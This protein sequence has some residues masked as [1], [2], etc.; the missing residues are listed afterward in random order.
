MR[1]RARR[2]RTRLLVAMMAIS[3]GVLVLAA[4]GAAGLARET[5]ADDALDDLKR[6]APTIARQLKTL[7]REAARLREGGLTG[8]RFCVVIAGLLRATGGSVVT[9]DANGVAS[10][11]FGGVLPCASSGAELVELP[12]NLTIADLDTDALLAG[13]LQSGVKDDTAFVAQPIAGVGN[14]IAVVVLTQAVE[15]RPLGQAGPYLFFT[16]LF[17]LILAAIVSAFLARRLTRPLGAMESTAGRIAAGDLSAR[18]GAASMPY[19]ELGSLAHSIDTM[20]DELETSRGHERAFLL[21]I[22]HDLRTPLTSIKGYAEGMADGVIESAP[23]RAR[24][25]AVI[26]A[27][28]RRLERLVADLLDL[29]R[30]DTHEFS[31]TRV[32]VDARATVTATVQGFAPALGELGVQLSVSSGA[33]INMNTDPERLA[34]IV[35]NL[36]ENAL[37]YAATS[38]LVDVSEHDGTVELRVDDDGPGIP[39]TERGRVFDRLYTV[40][41][42]P[43]RKVGTGIGLAIV[44]ELALAMGGAATCEPLDTGGTRFVVRLPA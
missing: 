27:E 10:E 18:V 17:A 1:K 12:R 9:V 15:T 16:S 44:H 19:E 37:K 22:S 21:S 32:P 6:Q 41:D 23:D 39:E 8:E 25:A 4:L 13:D 35:A 3:L 34:Q 14:F 26:V 20:A 30:L 7:G 40:R 33:P 5:S 24:A 29:A 42:S 2:L 38:V 11:D 28:A 36:V 43:G 31:L